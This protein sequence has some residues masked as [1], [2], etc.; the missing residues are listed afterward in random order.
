[1]CSG[2]E[3]TPKRMINSLDKVILG[4]DQMNFILDN[5]LMPLYRI[6]EEVIVTKLKLRQKCSNKIHFIVNIF[7]KF[8]LI[9]CFLIILCVVCF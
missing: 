2:S 6:K 8:N 4:L 9:I 1:M 3:E 5:E 7:F